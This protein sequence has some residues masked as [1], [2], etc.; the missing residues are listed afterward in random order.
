MGSTVLACPQSV[1]KLFHTLMVLCELS[2]VKSSLFLHQRVVVPS[3][4]FTSLIS[5]KILASIFS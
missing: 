5:K 3:S 1:D 4:Y 2:N